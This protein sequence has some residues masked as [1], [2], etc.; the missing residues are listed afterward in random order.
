LKK[1][2]LNFQRLVLVQKKKVSS[3]D[4]V[5]DMKLTIM[6]NQ[7]NF[8]KEKHEKEMEVLEVELKIKTCQLAKIKSE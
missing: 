6:E 3:I 4:V 5:N 7:L 1:E 8:M 2:N